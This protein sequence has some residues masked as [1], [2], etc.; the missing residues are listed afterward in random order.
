MKVTEKQLRKY[1]RSLIKENLANLG[2]KKATPFGKKEE[3]KPEEDKKDKEEKLEEAMKVDVLAFLSPKENQQLKAW[4]DGNLELP[5]D[6]EMKLYDYY[7]DEMPYGTMKARTGDPQHWLRSKLS[8]QYNESRINLYGESC[9]KPHKESALDEGAVDRFEMLNKF[10]SKLGLTDKE[11]LEELVFRQM[12][13]DEAVEAFDYIV[14]MHDLSSTLRSDLPEIDRYEMTERTLQELGGEEW[15]LLDALI[16]QMS[17]QE[18]EEAFEYLSRMHD[19]PF[20]EDTFSEAS[21]GSDDVE[22]WEDNKPVPGPRDLEI[23]QAL[24]EDAEPKTLE[25]SGYQNCACRDCMEIAIGEEGVYCEECLEAGCPESLSGECEAPGAYGG[26]DMREAAGEIKLTE[27]LK[28]SKSDKQVIQNF[29]NKKSGGNRK[30]STN[31]RELNGNWMGGDK[32]A[33]WL[34]DK[35]V[36]GP[37]DSRSKQTVQRFVR[38]LMPEGIQI[39]EEENLTENVI[40]GWIFY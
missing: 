32:I 30:F 25:E 3:E 6:L 35:L 2:D 36:M 40:P 28:L 8:S 5:N 13:D 37:L 12:S 26:G 17:D 24:E 19:I 34:K 9:G 31:G 27:E 7:A 11:M 1:I 21:D 16:R 15:E 29:V 23:Q 20:K 39:E 38:K 14:A 18:V 4:L 10:Q 33:F 22:G